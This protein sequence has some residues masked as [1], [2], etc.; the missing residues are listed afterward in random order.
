[1]TTGEVLALT[2]LNSGISV[3]ATISN[4][5]VIFAV[6]LNRQLRHT[7]TTVLLINLSLF[8]L[9]ICAMYVPMYIYDINYRSSATFEDMRFRM[10]FGLFIGSL[11]REFSV[12][13]NRFISICFPYCYVTWMTKICISF[14]VSAPWFVAISLTLLSLLTDTPLYNFFSPSS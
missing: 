5:L 2:V 7:C 9:I 4:I 11:N 14:A 8:D 3:I 13:L 12:T 10:I 1:M 6:L